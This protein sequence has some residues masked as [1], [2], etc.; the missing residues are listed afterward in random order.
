VVTVWRAIAA[1]L[2]NDSLAF[3][4]SFHCTP[5]G[6]QAPPPSSF[7]LSFSS[8]HT[9]PRSD[10]FFKISLARVSVCMAAALRCDG[11]ARLFGDLFGGY[12]RGAHP[13]PVSNAPE[14][15]LDSVHHGHQHRLPKGLV[16]V[17]TEF[18]QLHIIIFQA[19]CSF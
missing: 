19:A 5:V 16:Q 7:S 10:V 18:L 9:R 14:P 11:R 15:E 8:S 3:Q 17:F 6:R 12:G 2:S 4:K 13:G 1:S